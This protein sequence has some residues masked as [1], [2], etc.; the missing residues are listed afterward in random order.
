[1]PSIKQRF[2]NNAVIFCAG[3]AIGAFTLGFGARG[4]FIDPPQRI[5]VSC[6]VEGISSIEQG[7]TQRLATLQSSL[8]E[9]ETKASDRMIISSYQEQY[10]AAADRIRK[11]IAAEQANYQ[12]AINA[13]SKKCADA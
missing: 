1:M 13:L 4:Y 6:T 2:E 5:P 9:H 7:Y 11:D 8:V 3:L 12:A 10:R